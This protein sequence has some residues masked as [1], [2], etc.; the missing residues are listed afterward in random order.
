[1][2]TLPLQ[3]GIIYGPIR[4]RRLGWSLGLNVSPTGYKLCSFN[5]VYCHYGWTDVQTVDMTGRIGD[6][7]TP[8]DFERALA[9]ALREHQDKEINNITF[10]GN[11][12]ATLHPRFGELVDRAK[13]LKE[14]YFPQAKLGVLSNSSAVNTEGVREALA[15]LDFRIVKLD[16]GDVSTFHRINRP[17]K[18]VSYATMLDGLKSLDNIILQTV[19]VDGKISNTGEPELNEWVERVGEIQ[20]SRAQIYS[21]HRPPAESSLREVPEERLRAIG[22]QT[23]DKTGVGVEVIVAASPYSRRYHDPYRK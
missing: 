14:K 3:S 22:E 6:L 2:R 12:E 5:C 11:G 15:K 4:S 7:P 10:S 17:C 18:Q 1:M 20:P 19:F 13:R 16:A 21:L 9:A 8:D 23:G